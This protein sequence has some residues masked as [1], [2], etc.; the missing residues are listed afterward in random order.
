MERGNRRQRKMQKTVYRIRTQKHLHNRIALDMLR[1][2]QK[3]G[4]TA[5]LNT[6]HRERATPG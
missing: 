1:D 2:S 3:D 5:T 4:R 6:L